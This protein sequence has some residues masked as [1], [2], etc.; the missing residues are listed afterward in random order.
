MV[1]RTTS[2]T[3]ATLESDELKL[4]ISSLMV[5]LGLPVVALIEDLVTCCSSGGSCLSG[6]RA[7][8]ES[9]ATDDGVD[10]RGKLSRRDNGIT[11]ELGQGR[12]VDSEQLSLSTNGSGQ[13]GQSRLLQSHVVGVYTRLA[14]LLGNSRRIETEDRSWGM[15]W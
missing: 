10:V 4:A 3:Y 13:G 11:S 12:A 6:S 1:R 7:E 8:G 9:G 14:W 15:T 5:N 2:T